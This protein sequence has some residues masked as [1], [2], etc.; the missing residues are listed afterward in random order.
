MTRNFR[1]VSSA[2]LSCLLLRF[3]VS[4]LNVPQKSAAAQ[5]GHHQHEIV[6]WK[7]QREE[8]EEDLI[9]ILVTENGITP[10]TWEI[11]LIHHHKRQIKSHISCLYGIYISGELSAI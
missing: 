11:N 5:Y 7:R 10:T 6:Q 8:I 2:Q 1:R 4:T 3:H 9:G